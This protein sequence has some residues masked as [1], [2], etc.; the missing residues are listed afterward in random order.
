MAKPFSIKNSQI[1]VLIT[2]MVF[3]FLGA[4]YFFIYVPNN[5]KIVQERYFKCLQNIDYNIH[6]KI[7]NSELQ[8]KG[9][10][11]TDTTR[12]IK[13]LKN[14]IKN[15]P[16]DNFTLI[17]ERRFQKD[18]KNT[19]TSEGSS[20][21]IDTNRQQLT[22]FIN[23]PIFKERTRDTVGTTRMGVRY[24][25]NQFIKPL[26]PAEDFENYVVF[27][28]R[29]VLYETF[30]SGLSYNKKDSVL[31]L[32]NGIVGP[33]THSMSIGGRDYVVFSQ[34][35]NVHANK[36]LMIVGLVSNKNYQKE[37]NQLPLSAVLLLLTIAIAMIVSL[38]WIKLYHM[39]NKDKLTATDGVS[40]VLIAMLLMS[41]LFFAVFKYSFYFSTNYQHS[42][43]SREAL[44][45]QII[46]AFDTDLDTANRLLNRFDLVHRDLKKNVINLGKDFAKYQVKPGELVYAPF[47]KTHLNLQ[48]IR[49]KNIDIHQVYWLDTTGMEK[50]NWISDDIN[51]PHT[52]FGSRNYFINTIKGK[53][54]RQ[55]TS[56]VYVDQVVSRVSGAFTSIIAK[57][58]KY[59]APNIAAMSFTAKSLDSVVM[60]D[61]YQFAVIDS[62]GEVLYHSIADR[63][64]NENILGE[65]ADSTNLV[66]ALTA[67]SDTSFMVEYYGRR[68]NLK[69]KP[70]ADLPYFVVTLEDVE[71]NDA[72]D[73]ESYSFTLLMLSCL[74]IF[75]IIQVSVMFFVSAKRSFF[76]KQLFETGWIGPKTTSHHQY[77]LAILANITI[78]ILLG[79]FFNLGSF[80]KY[81][82]ILL[83]SITAVSIFLNCI[84]AKKYKDEQKPDYQRYKTD[85]IIWL[86]GFVAAI[87]LLACY[88]LEW[89]HC[90]TLLEFELLL[91]AVC[92]AVYF[93]GEPLLAKALEIKEK[94]PDARFYWNYTQS[95]A[96]MAATRLVITSGIP[97]AFFF[98]YSFNYEQNLDTRY[99]QMNF[100]QALVQKTSPNDFVDTHTGQLKTVPLNINGVYPD[101]ASIKKIETI[102]K[103]RNAP[104]S[105]EDA[106]TSKIL[107]MSRL[108]NNNLEVKSNNL[109]FASAGNKVSFNNINQPEYSTDYTTATTYKLGDD[110]YLKLSAAQID[111]PPLILGFWILLAVAL[112]LF[113]YVIYNIIRKLFA[114]NLPATNGW[115]IMDEKLL[116]DNKLNPLLFILGSPGSGKLKM[117]KA[118]LKVNKYTA[119]Q[120]KELLMLEETNQLKLRKEKLAEYNK[121]KLLCN[122]GELLIYDEDDPWN[123]NVFIADLILISAEN[124]EADPDWKQCKDEAL[125]TTYS[126][127]IINHFEYNIKDPRANS[128]K[129]NFLESLMQ[130]GKSKIMIVSTV[131]PL[132]FLDSFNEQQMIAAQNG[133][134]PE[135][136]LERWHVLLGHFR[137]AIEPLI[138]NSKGPKGKE[139]KPGATPLERA[140]YEETRYSHYLDN[141]Y[142]MAMNTVPMITNEDS[143]DIS[144][145][146]IF[147]LQI[148]SH[149]FY[150]YIWQSLT[151]EEKFLL[152]D[153]AEDGL[154]NPFDDYNLS[155]LI[156]KGLIMKQ[157]GTLMLFNKGFRNFILTAIGNTELNRLKDQVKDNGNW[158]SLK[159]PIIIAIMA[160]L[161][162]L[163]A[164]QQEAYSRIIAYI[165]AL[166]AGVPAVLKIFSLFP[167]SSSKEQ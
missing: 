62:T 139:L 103:N 128:I 117:I 121:G 161:V 112:I 64:L 104:Y 49:A 66:S 119:D 63:N 21:I 83:V 80:L 13:I 28:G 120:E 58:S 61:G 10:F 67:K 45:A 34:P 29:T 142:Q 18:K 42:Q 149:Y 164:S 141:M 156:S 135:S 159:T 31:Q 94:F 78:I 1:A 138:D 50:D 123:N 5:E 39:G 107:S 3:I 100:A 87:D 65:L 111:Y 110:K 75:M 88:T 148:T 51:A 101:G 133:A 48:S 96:M 81:L 36:E 95:F 109:N 27:Y 12:Q 74:L 126:L 157:Y 26:L 40:S 77:N 163:I 17:P 24:E 125:K 143:S 82:Y 160:I 144:D 146:V 130:R 11:T 20:V 89:K 30:P 165:T 151:K 53:P 86:S 153:L 116:V 127:V 147:K 8:V 99:R 91:T 108:L 122:S 19:A 55:D 73:T 54:N 22:L 72:R 98:I 106:L 166:G 158:G 44:P 140:I 14:Y 115:E 105:S 150:T 33:G 2:L 85:A 124:G 52:N 90:I 4:C 35:V 137:I 84:F 114:L 68:C 6:S 102:S 41:F 7:E 47:D 46:K 43:N 155:M 97:V 76:K 92:L 69:V 167:N 162:F 32:R 70:F 23:S 9:L 16:K 57:R 71:Y 56:K 152:Y 59:D 136:E 37:K 15:Y 113:Y 118:K 129:L 134:I 131:H 60:P 25:F 38:P 132:T 79:C 93:I 145:S 154:V